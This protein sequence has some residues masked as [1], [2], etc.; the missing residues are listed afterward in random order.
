M[1]KLNLKITKREI[2]LGLILIILGILTRTYLHIGPNIEFVT[3]ITLASG[4]F[5]KDKK[6]ALL[7]P[8]GVL[9][10][11]DLFIGNT[12]IFVFTWSGFL[13]GFILATLLEKFSNKKVGLQNLL[14]HSQSLGIIST[15]V[16]FLWTNFGV[17]V[18]TTMYQHN[19]AGLLLSYEMGLP[20][21]IN[22]L[23]SNLV[24]VPGVFVLSRL[25]LQEKISLKTNE[26][27]ASK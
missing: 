1:K 18:T 19:L 21:L 3:A 27:Q 2:I 12:L 9:L 23:A 24:I 11:T 8:F 6:I 16:F 7:I 17:L 22:Q 15:F 25:V 4:Y 13:F 5:F 26:W 14:L 20:F 10:V